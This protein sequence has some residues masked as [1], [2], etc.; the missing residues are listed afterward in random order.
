MPDTTEISLPIRPAQRADAQVMAA[1]DASSQINPWTEA[2]FAQVCAGESGLGE[3][4]LVWDDGTQVTGYVVFALVLGEASVHRIAVHP[5][6]R[7]RGIGQAI[8]RAAIAQLQC[9]GASRCLLE[10]RRSNTAAKRLYAGNGFRVDGVRK[11]YYPAQVG[12]E[13]ALLMSREL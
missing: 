10:V 8:L 4:A 2:Q 11:N 9:M 13:D 6:R 12:R 5:G 1:I 3:A 7:G